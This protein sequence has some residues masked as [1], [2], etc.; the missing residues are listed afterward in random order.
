MTV[1]GKRVVMAMMM[2][3]RRVTVWSPMMQ[4]RQ[5]PVAAA[6]PETIA[7]AAPTTRGSPVAEAVALTVPVAVTA[8]VRSSMTASSVAVTVPVAVSMAAA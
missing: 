2:G 7:K 3:V 8:A 1:V 6:V 4:R 5:S